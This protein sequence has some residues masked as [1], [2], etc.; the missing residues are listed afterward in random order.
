MSNATATDCIDD[1]F[2]RVKLVTEFSSDKVVRVYSE[3]DLLDKSKLIPPPFT[4]VMYEGIR[5][6]ASDP[7]RLGRATDC[8]V[9]IVLGCLTK[10]V[11]GYDSR[12]EAIGLLDSIRNQILGDRS[13]SQHRWKFISELY[14]GDISNIMI[15]IQR[16]STPLILSR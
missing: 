1:I 7:G 16:W 10:A 6:N 12:P 15:Y 3:T 2:N 9:A 11:G 8:Y 5:A 4:G 14:V 13:P